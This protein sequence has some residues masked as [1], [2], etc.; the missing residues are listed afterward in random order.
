MARQATQPVNEDDYE[1]PE[2][3]K[4]NTQPRQMVAI[5]TVDEQG[6]VNLE[7]ASY[8]AATLLQKFGE[9]SRSGS[10]PQILNITRS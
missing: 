10:N 9:L 7:A 3:K 4:R 5:V 1:T 6:K 8:N 2:K